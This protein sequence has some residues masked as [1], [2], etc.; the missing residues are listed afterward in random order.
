MR[1][2]LGRRDDEGREAR[3]PIVR[4]TPGKPPEIKF[5]KSS[6]RVPNL[7]FAPG[8]AGVVAELSVRWFMMRPLDP[9]RRKGTSVAAVLGTVVFVLLLLLIGGAALF[10]RLYNDSQ[11]RLDDAV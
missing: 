10:R 9:I 5:Y 4:Q 3:H 1:H 8:C 11:R 6:I 7:P 2:K